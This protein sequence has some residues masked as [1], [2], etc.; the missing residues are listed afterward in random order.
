MDFC[1]LTGIKKST[2]WAIVEILTEAEIK[3]K[4][5]GG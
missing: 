5:S 4:A 2:F 1:R 3:K